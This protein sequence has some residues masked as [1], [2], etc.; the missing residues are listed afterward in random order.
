MKVLTGI[1]KQFQVRYEF[2]ISIYAI[3]MLS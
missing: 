2:F 1:Y 3:F